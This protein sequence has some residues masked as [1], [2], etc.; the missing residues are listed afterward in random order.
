[1]FRIPCAQCW[2]GS[3]CPLQVHDVGPHSPGGRCCLPGPQN[4][5]PTRCDCSGVWVS[6][7]NSS[8]SFRVCKLDTPRPLECL[9]L[10]DGRQSGPSEG[11]VFYFFNNAAPLWVGPMLAHE[12]GSWTPSTHYWLRKA[13]SQTLCLKKPMRPWT[14]CVV[15]FITL[16]I[17][18]GFCNQHASVQEFLQVP[19]WTTISRT[20]SMRLLQYL[21]VKS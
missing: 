1:M 18:R 2:G 11:L 14:F 13:W 21:C 10:L 15:F 12:T 16:L 20:W 8:H 17:V 5:F 3:Q 9:H 6:D 7:A 19:H 4:C